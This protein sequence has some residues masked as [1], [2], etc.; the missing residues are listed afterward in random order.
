MRSV[1]YSLSSVKLKDEQKKTKK[2]QIKVNRKPVPKDGIVGRNVYSTWTDQ[3]AVL[4]DCRTFTDFSE[5]SL[6][7]LQDKN[8][9]IIL[10]YYYYYYLPHSYSI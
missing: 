3:P 5:L 2:R 1:R 4:Q 8:T 10:Y 9:H 7:K 6:S